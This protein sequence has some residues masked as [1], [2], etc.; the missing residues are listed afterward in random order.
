MKFCPECKIEVGGPEVHC[1]LCG[2]ELKKSNRSDGEAN[3]YPDFTA[4]TKHRSK[5]PPLAKV[6]A[7]LSLVAVFVCGLVDLLLN[8]RLTW[9][10]FVIGGI[11]ALWMSVGVHLLSDINLSNKLLLDLCALSFYL[12]LIDRLTGWSQWSIDYVIPILYMGVMITV[13]I[14]ALVFRNYWR[15]YILS[16]VSVCVLGLGPLLIFFNSKSPMRYLC[17][18]AALMAAAL[19][20]GLLFFAGGKVFSEWQRRMNI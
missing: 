2:C 17:L 18:A 16:L 7:F 10:L 9:S 11:A 13:I 3:L 6:F 14:L 15:E 4:V 5:F 1:P 12:M 20:G 19:A 8:R